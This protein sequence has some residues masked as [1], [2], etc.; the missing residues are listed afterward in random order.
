MA[1]GTQKVGFF[2]R[3]EIISGI[4]LSEVM[5]PSAS[6]VIAALAAQKQAEYDSGIDGVLSV[7]L[8]DFAKV[9]KTLF[10]GAAQANQRDSDFHTPRQ[11][12]HYIVM[13]TYDQFR[14]DESGIEF[15]DA[16]VIAARADCISE[17]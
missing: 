13:R 9:G 10:L 11:A 12:A 3:E 15:E 17:R 8:G 16:L 4:A 7:A 14:V 2:Q 6:L 5:H 1:A